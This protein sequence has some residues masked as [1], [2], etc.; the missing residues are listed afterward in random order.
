MGKKYSNDGDKA[1][2]KREM[3]MF[4]ELQPRREDG[5]DVLDSTLLA[6]AERQ[7]HQRIGIRRWIQL[8]PA[9]EVAHFVQHHRQK[10]HPAGGRTARLG[11]AVDKRLVLNGSGPRTSRNPP[12]RR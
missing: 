10:V 9:V 12:R 3:F 4:E 7:V 2:I 8:G 6:G 5:V 11:N 1:N